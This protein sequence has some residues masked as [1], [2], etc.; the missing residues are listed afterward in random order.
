[1]ANQLKKS[2]PGYHTL[3]PGYH[4]NPHTYVSK[5]P[6]FNSS[7]P[8]YQTSHPGYYTSPPGYHT[9]PYSDQATQYSS[10]PGY[11]TSQPGYQSGQFSVPPP[12]YQT[13]ASGQQAYPPEYQVYP[14]DQGSKLPSSYTASA[15]PQHHP[16]AH[17]MKYPDNVQDPANKHAKKPLC[18]ICSTVDRPVYHRHFSSKF[19]MFLM[20]ANKPETI[21]Y[22]CPS[23]KKL[24]K[25]NY[26]KRIKLV[27]STSTLHMWFAPPGAT[28]VLYKG[29]T[30]HRDYVTIPGAKIVHLHEAFMAEYGTVTIGMDIVLVAGLNDVARGHTR[31]YIMQCITDFRQAVAKQ[32]EDY[33]PD[34]MNTFAVSALLYP[35]QLCWFVD[36]G[37]FPHPDYK[38]NLEKVD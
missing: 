17:A 2:R 13:N 26:Q 25:P 21:S 29:D 7:H 15:Q 3:P 10:P 5:P 14:S 19:G 35:P 37:P 11:H 36:S 9:N 27:M 32:A 33:H 38:N 31:T 6:E 22:N 1:M 23:C 30:A 8:G 18:R 28:D 20:G 24:H 12:D 34:V 16:P 4:T